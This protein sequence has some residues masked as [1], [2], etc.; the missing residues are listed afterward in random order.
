M[1]HGLTAPILIPLLGG[2]LQI[3]MGYAP[4]RPAA[5]ARVGHHCSDAVSG[6]RFY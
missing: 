2:I 5:H 4:I 1:N 3:F 6:H